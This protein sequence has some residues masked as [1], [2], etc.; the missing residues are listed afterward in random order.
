[1]K[2]GKEMQCYSGGFS[3]G[4]KRT[5]PEVTDSCAKILSRLCC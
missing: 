1:M 3:R 2:N 5:H 4:G